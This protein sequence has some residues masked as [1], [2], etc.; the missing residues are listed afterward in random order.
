[1]ADEADVA[2]D[3]AERWLKNALAANCP[4]IPEGSP[5]ECDWCGEHTPRLVKRA[6]AR[7][8]DKFK[9]G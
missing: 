1:M 5:G 3:Y 6:C 2:N 8:R 4:E 7:C 9:L